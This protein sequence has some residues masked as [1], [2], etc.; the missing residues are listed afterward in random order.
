MKINNMEKKFVM[1]KLQGAWL[2]ATLGSIGWVILLIFSSLPFGGLKAIASS[3]WLAIP[4]SLLT[5]A[6]SIVFLERI[7]ARA[8]SFLCGVLLFTTWVFFQIGILEIV[9]LAILPSPNGL[10]LFGLSGIMLISIA[11]IDHL[12]GHPDAEIIIL[13]LLIA[14]QLV[15]LPLNWEYFSPRI[16]VFTAGLL[17]ADVI[18]VT[19]VI[20]FELF[21]FVWKEFR[22]LGKKI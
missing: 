11:G 16:R 3:T 18:I 22:P 15:G 10:S 21:R 2:P 1:H 4:I 9:S 17:F 12:M 6:L 20:V 5:W 13:V 7:H 8:L 19:C 14:N